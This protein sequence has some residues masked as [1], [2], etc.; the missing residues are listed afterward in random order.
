MLIHKGT[1]NLRQQGMF[2]MSS[3]GEPLGY[4]NKGWPDPD[5][6]AIV[7]EMRKALAA[8]RA[9]SSKQRL[10]DAP[11]GKED[12]IPFEEDAFVK[13]P[14]T[15]DLRI[16][17]R[18]LPYE[19]M[20]SFDQRHPMYYH[21]DRLWFSPVRWRAFLPSELKPGAS[22]VVTGPARTRIVLLSHH[23]AGASAWW[24]EHITGGQTV[25]KVVKLEG[26]AVHIRITGDYVM[27]ANSEWCKDKYRGELIV[28]AI[29]S[30]SRDEFTRF[31]LGMLGTHTVGQRRENLHAGVLTSKIAA[32]ASINPLTDADDRM[33]PQ[34]WKWGYTVEWCRRP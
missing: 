24:E 29:Y 3:A 10:L 15:L 32:T 2:V 26:D 5:P 14:K 31:D 20:T 34:N 11:L 22:T 17:S 4:L 27:S 18:G 8:Y 1:Y 9:L 7:A 6:K 16:T 25:S 13:P 12:R 33:I 21:M 19:G 23:Q 28:E 30:K